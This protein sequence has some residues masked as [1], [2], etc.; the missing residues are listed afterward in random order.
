[1]SWLEQRWYSSKPAP[2]WLLPLE[3][4]FC[5]LAARK[6]AKDQL[7]RWQ[8]PVPVIIVGNIS[9]GG[10]GKT[11]LVEYLV[12]LLRSQGYAP[13]IVSR[14]YKS[15]AS[16]YPYLVDATAEAE[17][18]GDE[19]FLLHQRCQCPVAV[20]PNRV[21]AA[22][23]L[24]A[25]TSCDIIISDDGMQH[26]QLGRD[27]EIAVLD[28]QRGLG[29]Q[30]CLPAGPLREYPARLATVDFIVSNGP[31]E[32]DLHMEKAI[33]T[34]ALAPNQ[35]V[36]CLDKTQQ[37]LAQIT[38]ESVHGIAGIGNPERFFSAVEEL[39]QTAVI[40]HPMPDHHHYQS[41]DFVF[42]D[43]LRILMTEKD[44]VKV[45]S[46]ARKQMWYLEVSAQLPDNFATALLAQLDK[47][48][49]GKDN[50]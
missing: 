19:P 37:P 4:L 2:F 44:A 45:R 6:S 34:M 10:T 1:M 14:G 8:A 23:H 35:L 41:K 50:G 40:R 39:T 13:G 15:K 48:K 27:I 21:S 32:H 33:F 28:G 25:N 31:L 24:L 42:E 20:D 12:K 30:H 7:H 5:Q 16:H 36:N 47:V 3:K 43:N 9:V 17:Q 46:F 26:Y 22:Q 29:N 11:P 38:G 49:K 18:V